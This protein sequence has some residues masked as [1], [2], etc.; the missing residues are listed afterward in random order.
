MYMDEYSFRTFYNAI[1]TKYKCVY[2]LRNITWFNRKKVGVR[3]SSE[4]RKSA[5]SIVFDV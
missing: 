1:R 3:K 5:G 4:G 2:V